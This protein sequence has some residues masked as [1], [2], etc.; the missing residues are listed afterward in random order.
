MQYVNFRRTLLLSGIAVAIGPLP[1]LAQT[2][3]TRSEEQAPSDAS[4]TPEIV[5]TALKRDQS[6]QTVPAT[7]L[8]VD[9]EAIT[10]RGV[11]TFEDISRVAPAVNI[12]TAPTASNFSITIRGLGSEPGEAA[13]DSSVS[14]FVDG[15]YTPRSREF[16]ASLFD[17]DSIQVV[18][19][20]QAALLGKNTSLGAVALSTRKPGAN[21]AGDFRVGHELELGS[22]LAE[23]GVDL[24][25]SDKFSIR[26]AGRYLRDV[27]AT[28][29]VIDGSRATATSRAGRIVARWSP[30]TDV[31]VTAMYQ[32]AASSAVG[33]RAELIR[34]AGA[35]QALGAAAGYPGRVEAVLDYRTAIYSPTLDGSSFE[36]I[37]AQRG[38]LTIDWQLGAY[39]LTAQTGYT[40]SDFK[41]EV[42]GDFVPGDYSVFGATDRSRQFT[43]ELRL[44]SPTGETFDFIVGALFLRGI[45]ANDATYNQNFPSPAPGVPAI[46]GSTLTNFYQRNS[47]VSV[48]GQGNLSLTEALKASVGLRY[49]SEKKSAD[50]ARTAT[51]PG[52]YSLVAS[53]PFAPFSLSKREGNVDASF[54]LSYQ[55]SG[56]ALIYASV[57][58]G[59]K[60]GGYASSVTDLRTARY[61]PERARTAELGIK[62]QFDDRRITVNV[63][64]F[65]TRVDDYQLVSY[66]GVAFVTGNTDLRSYGVES[67]LSWVP[68]RNFTIYSNNT[69]AKA[70]DLRLGLEATHAPVWSGVAGF[71][72]GHDVGSSLRLSAQGALNYRSSQIGQRAAG[73]PRLPASTRIDLSLGV[74]DRDSGV[75]LRLIGK[76]L[77][78]ERKFGFLFPAP[79]QPGSV[80]GIPMPPRTIML[81]LSYGSR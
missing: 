69:W 47:A 55:M 3:T 4:V 57:G 51:V 80:V 74:E 17:V 39:N 26:V 64:G 2:A 27:G 78:N 25:V 28:V 8:N 10:T 40:R 46:F 73:L 38:A 71:D 60:A 50:L 35:S 43:Q 70:K 61:E 63:A 30:T 16:S 77:N 31:D 15:V 13:F 59:T 49:T 24:P 52:F 22:I 12:N 66:N 45:Y 76:N 48:F 54:G 1:V 75:A 41:Q 21:Y 56:Q 53:P 42:D 34:S 72:A 18:K 14:L 68:S 44:V 36:Y 62:T 79:L 81:Q 32:I 65:Y 37:D 20:G 9:A 7:V 6:L 29:N 11:T 58:Q 23:G 19:G 67:Q 33:T 5:V